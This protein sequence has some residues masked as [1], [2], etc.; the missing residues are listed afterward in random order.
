MPFYYCYRD[1]E[2]DLE[3]ITVEEIEEEDLSKGFTLEKVLPEDGHRFIT[4][5]CEE[6]IAA[7]HSKAALL[8]LS[9]L[10]PEIIK[11]SEIT[12]NLADIKLEVNVIS[13]KIEKLQKLLAK[14]MEESKTEC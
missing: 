13:K 7:A 10:S 1:V 6:D 3:Q 8:L 4:I 2:F 11:K 12:Y 9:E 14:F 5:L